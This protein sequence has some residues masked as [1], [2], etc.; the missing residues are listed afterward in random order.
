MDFVKILAKFIA[1]KNI[2]KRFG[3]RMLIK[4]F[5]MKINSHKP[6]MR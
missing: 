3:I 2:I 5:K 4:L 1:R 6:K